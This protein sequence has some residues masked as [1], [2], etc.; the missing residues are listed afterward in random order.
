M[1]AEKGLHI[2][3]GTFDRGAVLG[4]GKVTLSREIQMVK[5]GLLYGDSAR[6]CSI[7]ASLVLSFQRFAETESIRERRLSFRNIRH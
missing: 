6:L 4:E 7:A 1:D 3:V 5:A 2:T